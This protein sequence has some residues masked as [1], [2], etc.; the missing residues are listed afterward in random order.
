MPRPRRLAAL[1]AGAA[2]VAV[3]AVLTA[4][5]AV[6]DH[7]PVPS[8]V[9]LMGSLME[10][11]GCES[12]WSET[13]HEDRP[14]AGAGLA[15]PVRRHVHRAR[16]RPGRTVRLPL[17][18]AAQR[19]AGPR[20]TATPRSAS[21]T[22]TSPWRSTRPRACASPTTTR[23]TGSGSAR[24]QPAGG[25]TAADRAMAG[26]SLREDLTREN[27]YF[28]MADRFEN[29]DAGQRHRRHRR[30]PAATTATTRPARPSTT[31]ATCRGSST[32]STTSRTS[33]RRRSG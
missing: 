17:Q 11:L 10:E 22:A 15:D 21:P 28:V 26:D 1:A 27:F 5:P 29:G 6:A 20:T 30:H 19:R 16:G 31:A 3:P 4:S 24:P 2:L 18:G 33:A 32:G 7:T 23:P 25:L 12:D 8:R 13:L 14:A 9:T